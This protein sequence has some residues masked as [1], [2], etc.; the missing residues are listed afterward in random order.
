ML[1]PDK[2]RQ[3][4][5]AG[6]AQLK[7]HPDKL[8]IFIEKGGVRSTA[9]HSLSFE[10]AYTLVIFV[11]DYEG[12][13]DTLFVPVLAW[14]RVNQPEL[15]LHPDRQK[16]GISFEAEILNHNSADIEIKLNLTERVLVSEDKA[17]GRCTVSHIGEPPLPLAD[18]GIAWQLV[19]ENDVIRE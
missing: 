9:A 13:P 1:K 14:L 18:D 16:D 11:E 5:T 3:A 15:L 19:F 10:Y 6:I 17:T 4:L 8:R 12:H 7:T 2:L